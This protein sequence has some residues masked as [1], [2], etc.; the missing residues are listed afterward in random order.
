MA[1]A[2]SM[3]ASCHGSGRTVCTAAAPRGRWHRPSA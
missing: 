1:F 3:R 2:A